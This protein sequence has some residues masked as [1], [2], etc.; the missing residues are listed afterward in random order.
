MIEKVVQSWDCSFEGKATSDY[1]AC[2]VWGKCGANLYLLYMLRGKWDF[3]QTVQQMRNM[4]ALF[5]QT[6]EKLIERKANGSAIIS[7]LQ[8]EIIGLVPYDVGTDSKEARMYAASFAFESGNIYFPVGY[9]WVDEVV[10]ELIVFPN[11]KN[12]DICDTISQVI[13]KLTRPN[14]SGMFHTGYAR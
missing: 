12:D 11:G 4:C 8:N 1:V 9:P 5:P 14:N 10:Q 13:L 6:S 2:T 7:L 3:V